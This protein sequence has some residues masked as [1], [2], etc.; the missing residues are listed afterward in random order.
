MRHRRPVG[1]V[2]TTC[3][4]LAI[5]AGAASAAGAAP[6]AAWTRLEWKELPANEG[7]RPYHT[8][9]LWGMTGGYQSTPHVDTYHSDLLGALAHFTTRFNFDLFL[10]APDSSVSYRFYDRF[11]GAEDSVAEAL[12]GVQSVDHVVQE[13]D[14][15]VYNASQ[16][17]EI[18]SPDELGLRLMATTAAGVDSLSREYS[19]FA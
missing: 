19:L 16:Y 18:R 10:R 7:G 17:Y 12:A 3:G 15:V 1:L 2:V 14:L 5:L 13:G 11:R 8:D 4:L 6:G 9:M